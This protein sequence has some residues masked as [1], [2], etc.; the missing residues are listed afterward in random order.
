[1]DVPAHMELAHQHLLAAMDA[2]FQVIAGSMQADDTVSQSA[3]AYVVSISAFY[4]ELR[5]ESQRIIALFRA[6]NVR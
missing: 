3:Q 5:R 1:M 6:V 2:V 4:T